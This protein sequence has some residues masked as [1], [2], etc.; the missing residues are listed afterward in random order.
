LQMS[1]VKTYR[2]LLRRPWLVSV[3]V[4]AVATLV[5]A[6]AALV[7]VKNMG[8]F[9]A[10]QPAGPSIDGYERYTASMT[11]LA[12]AKDDYSR[13]LALGDAALWSVNVGRLDDA[14]AYA[15]E[16]HAGLVKYRTDWNYGN[17]V[18]KAHSAHGRVALQRGDLAR[19]IRELA[20]AGASPGSPQMDS[21]GPNL[22]LARDLLATNDAIARDAVR[23][24]FDD[25]AKF[26]RLEA[27]A[28]RVWRG[29]IAAGRAPNFGAT[30]LF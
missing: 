3:L 15:R 17:A 12:D 5:I 29:D 9:M 19:A 27:G 26:W 1:A 23:A 30:L 11:K 13:W 14:S 21:F 2:P 6:V 18:S 24:H 8:A 28:L 7:F 4:G 22:S 10:N 25:I 16:L 20:L